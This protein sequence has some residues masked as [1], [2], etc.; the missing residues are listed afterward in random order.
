M[1]TDPQFAQIRFAR[2][3]FAVIFSV[4]TSYSRSNIGDEARF[5]CSILLVDYFRLR[6]ARSADILLSRAHTRKALATS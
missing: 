1:W 2:S 6:R 5:Q 3:R 4:R